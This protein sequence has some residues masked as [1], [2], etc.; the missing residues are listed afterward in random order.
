MDVVKTEAIGPV[1][2]SARS[3]IAGKRAELIV[4]AVI[5]AERGGRGGGA[6]G[7][8][9]RVVGLEVGAGA[10]EGGGV[11]GGGGIPIGEGRE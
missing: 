8:V 5:V 9:S 7:G 4:V 6:T 2:V 10:G 11:D 1:V 3:V